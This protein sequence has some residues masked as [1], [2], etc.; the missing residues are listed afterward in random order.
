MHAYLLLAKLYRNFPRPLLS[1]LFDPTMKI[2][3][4]RTCIQKGSTRERFLLVQI[5]GTLRQL[6]IDLL[7]RVLGFIG[8]LMAS[9]L[10]LLGTCVLPTR[11]SPPLII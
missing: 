6:R 10:G 9:C 5:R 2:S 4:P 3:I 11:G 7:S 1:E 8:V